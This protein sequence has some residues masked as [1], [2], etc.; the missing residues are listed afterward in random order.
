MLASFAQA[1]M[2][3]LMAAV[4]MIFGCR[5]EAI[6]AAASREHVIAVRSRVERAEAA[7][8]EPA[9][10]ADP[11]HR[12]RSAASLGSARFETSSSTLPRLRLSAIGDRK[13]RMGNFTY[14]TAR[15]RHAPVISL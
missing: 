2:L 4:R 7:E 6:P 14:P 10:K 12:F 1:L 8:A 3:W 5:P 13:R 15:R 11:F 9:A